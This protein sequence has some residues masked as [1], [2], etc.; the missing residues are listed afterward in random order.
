MQGMLDVTRN[1]DG[2]TQ[3]EA[4]IGRRVEAARTLRH[5]LFQSGERLSI[6]AEADDVAWHWAG[7]ARP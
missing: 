4:D 5:C 2:P 7:S 3:T 1:L 6:G